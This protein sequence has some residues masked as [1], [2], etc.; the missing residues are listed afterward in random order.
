M[1]SSAILAYRVREGVLLLE[2]EPERLLLELLDERLELLPE[3]LLEL[4]LLLGRALVPLELVPL[5]ELLELLGR[6]TLLEPLWLLEELL[7]LLGRVLELLL[8]ELLLG[9]T[10]EPLEELLELE[11]PLG[12]LLLEAGLFRFPTLLP[13]PLPLWLVPGVLKLLAPEALLGRTV[14]CGA[15]PSWW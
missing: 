15:V 3:R 9:R 11:L 6:L 5:D 4:E 8:E 2:L 14:A 13:L 12:R 1:R 7:E 10:L